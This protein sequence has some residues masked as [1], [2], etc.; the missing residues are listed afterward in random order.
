M[1][2]T[3]IP[4]LEAR[5]L[6]EARLYADRKHMIAALQLPLDGVVAEVG[7]ALG[8]FSTLLIA[9]LQP[10]EF[11][12]IDRFTLHQITALW[13]RPTTEIFQGADHRGFYAKVLGECPCVVTIREGQSHLMLETFPD[14]YFDLIYIDADHSYP[15]VKRDAAAAARKIKPNG[16]VIFND[17]ILFD[18]LA[19][20][21]Y[22]VVP[23][24]NELVV[25]EGWHV[26]GFSLHEQ[27][28]CDIAVCPPSRA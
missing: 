1:H 27:M 28:F 16:I 18:H 20:V 3:N 13:G 15:A 4:A 2:P 26:I 21:P 11:V 14:R 10:R 17:Y 19:G 8:N 25:H 7:V 5:H 6:A 22:G 24:V 12:A 9:A 23:A